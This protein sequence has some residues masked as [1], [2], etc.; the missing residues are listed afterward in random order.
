[1]NNH[2]LAESNLRP[3]LVDKSHSIQPV[4]FAFHKKIHLRLLFDKPYVFIKSFESTEGYI[5]GGWKVQ[6]YTSRTDSGRKKKVDNKARKTKRNRAVPKELTTATNKRTTKK[7]SKTTTITINE[8]HQ[9]QFPTG[10]NN[11]RKRSQVAS[12][13]GRVFFGRFGRDII[14]LLQH[15]LIEV[16]EELQV[17]EPK[18]ASKKHLK[19]WSSFRVFLWIK[20]LMLFIE[21]FFPTSRGSR[22][23]LAMFNPHSQHWWRPRSTGSW[24][25]RDGPKF[26]RSLETQQFGTP[27]IQ[28][29]PKKIGE[30]WWIEID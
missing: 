27:H 19:L 16:S 15:H 9:L 24:K 2:V 10:R 1:M 30:S 8:Q 21:C 29:Q 13:G 4:G 23:D 22:S 14:S 20:P 28:K 7:H 11:K 18:K 25:K 12:L 26:S 3:G 17:E 5:H 6:V